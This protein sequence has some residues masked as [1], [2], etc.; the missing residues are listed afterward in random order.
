L[1]GWNWAGWRQLNEGF[2]NS[3]IKG[4][5]PYKNYPSKVRKDYLTPGLKLNNFF[6]KGKGELE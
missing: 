5:K 1:E 3:K 2:N 4:F 6:F